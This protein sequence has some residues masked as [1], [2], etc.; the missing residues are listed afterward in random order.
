MASEDPPWPPG[1]AWVSSLLSDP[2]PR[3]PG[4]P[5]SA[6]W[7]GDAP[8]MG[9]A[10]AE[11]TGDVPEPDETVEKSRN[12]TAPPESTMTGTVLPAVCR[13]R[14]APT[15]PM[16]VL[17]QSASS[18]SASCATGSRGQWPIRADSRTRRSADPRSG[19]V[20][21]DSR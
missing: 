19:A 21:P 3:S 13:R 5:S 1:A 11:A 12:A 4:P 17:I 6:A 7:P 9:I 18:A 20:K 16:A 10:P 2:C 8:E 14:T 15:R